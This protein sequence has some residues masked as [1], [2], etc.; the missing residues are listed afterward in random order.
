MNIAC[1]SIIRPVLNR[2]L[3]WLACNSATFA[4]LS[5]P[6]SP[7]QDSKLKALAELAV[8]CRIAWRFPRFNRDAS[9]VRLR[10]QIMVSLPNAFEANE[11][12]LTQL[13]LSLALDACSRFGDGHRNRLAAAFA[14]EFAEFE[15]WH[16]W[17]LVELRY[18]L[19]LFEITHHIPNFST[20][21]YCTLIH[22]QPEIAKVSRDEA[23]RLTH[24]IF[25]MSDFGR[26]SL[27]SV[28]NDQFAQHCDYVCM[29]LRRF[30]Q[31][32]DWDLV[33]ELLACCAC[34][35]YTSEP[36]FAVGWEGLERSQSPSG[37]INPSR[38]RQS[39]IREGI[40][41]YHAMIVTSI[42][43]ILAL[44]LQHLCGMPQP[45]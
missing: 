1:R 38:V 43:A 41:H 35:R 4:G 11:S 8:L 21:Y 20:L 36:V 14:R 24:T 27:R 15:T 12:F 16:A 33:A 34:L 42:A 7:D 37:G 31:E 13:R 2:S 5:H 19:D 3:S 30:I 10:D 6:W 32:E 9:V 45:L 22:E 26:L 28:F 40:Y 23:Y 17:N 44:E 29:L 18:F 39:N 25:A